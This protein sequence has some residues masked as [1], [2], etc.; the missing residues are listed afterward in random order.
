[1]RTQAN[2]GEA[3]KLKVIAL[4]RQP[5]KSVVL[6]WRPMGNGSFRKV[7]AKHVARTV[8]KVALPAAGTDLEYYLRAETADGKDLLWPA[9]APSLNQTVVEH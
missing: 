1:V 7:D 9:T 8:Y 6:F 5:V 2:K 4:D 3:L